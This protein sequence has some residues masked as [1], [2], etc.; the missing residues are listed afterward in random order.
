[1]LL[2]YIEIMQSSTLRRIP[3]TFLLFAF[4][5]PK[6]WTL[7]AQIFRESATSSTHRATTNSRPE[8]LIFTRDHFSVHEREFSKIPCHVVTYLTKSTKE[9]QHMLC[10]FSPSVLVSRRL[11]SVQQRSIPSMTCGVF[12]E[13]AGKPGW[14]TGGLQIRVVDVLCQCLVRIELHLEQFKPPNTINNGSIPLREISFE[15]VLSLSLSVIRQ[16]MMPWVISVSFMNVCVEFT[17][18]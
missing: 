7:K 14:K 18:V 5:S 13:H 12:G 15:W 6:L 4:D 2:S 16:W 8:V 17:T 10:S 3:I 1:M 9:Q 11:T